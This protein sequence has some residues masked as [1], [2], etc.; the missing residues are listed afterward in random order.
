MKNIA[1]TVIGRVQGVWFRKY[2][3]DQANNL[4]L[5]GF[6]KNKLDGSVYIEASGPEEK[7]DYLVTWCKT[8]SPLSNVEDLLLEEIEFEHKQAFT[9]KS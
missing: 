7:I 6:V 9:I 4:E 5:K 2:T 8:G 3:M 1:I